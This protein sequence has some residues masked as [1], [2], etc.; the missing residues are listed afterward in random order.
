M[1]TFF[2]A[3]KISRDKRHLIPSKIMYELL[4]LLKEINEYEQQ[5][6]NENTKIKLTNRIDEISFLIKS[7]PLFVKRNCAVEGYM[8]KRFAV[9][10]KAIKSLKLC[11]LLPEGNSRKILKRKVESI[12]NIFAT[13]N[14]MDLPKAP[15]ISYP[16]E[17]SIKR[18]ST[19][20][21]FITLLSIAIFFIIPLILWAAVISL[22][23]FKVPTSIQSILPILYSVWCL[24]G[25]LSFSEK[26]APDTKVFVFDVLK[27][28]L[29]KK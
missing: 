25:L 23:N 10:A 9:A 16:L 6:I 12:F 3:N 17:E 26:L 7:M 15:Y 11:I 14:Y 4:K 5:N 8:D 13:G 2:D 24:I 22:Y 20:A 27:L 29:P 18:E 28:L 1:G 21:R 19:I